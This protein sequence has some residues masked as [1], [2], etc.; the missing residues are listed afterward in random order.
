MKIKSLYITFNIVLFATLLLLFFAPKLILSN[1]LYKE[2]A[3]ANNI[4]IIAL[5]IIITSINCIFFI[6]RKLLKC[7][8]EENWKGLAIHLHDK[9]Y[10]QKR[11]SARSVQLL[12]DSLLLTGKTE[13]IIEL[14]SF[15]RTENPKAFQKNLLR[16]AS[17]YV[18]LTKT[19]EARSVLEE[20]NTSV[21]KSEWVIW[22]H[23]FTFYLE[24]D[25]SAT[26]SELGNSIS[27]LQDPLVT[28]LSIFIIQQLSTIKESEY[29]SCEQAVIDK[30]NE[31]I[32]AFSRKKFHE[33]AEDQKNQLYCA[34]I[35]SLIKQAEDSIFN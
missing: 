13:E 2:M 8:E 20:A 18:L 7:L 29:K 24:R 15:V 12:C 17:S 27:K 23:A 32:V 9:I 30:K 10:T 11:F 4:F 19:A 33:Y 14:C 5:L 35:S 26:I 25:F 21:A 16:F 31:L 3:F 6:N 22:Y 1:D 34:I 28:A